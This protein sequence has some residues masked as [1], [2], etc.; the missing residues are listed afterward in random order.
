MIY[1]GP[2]LVVMD[3]GAIVVR[4]VCLEVSRVV[5]VGSKSST[6][7]MV[8]SEEDITLLGHIESW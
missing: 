6:S 2:V 7:S 4:I 1:N 3:R 5:Y 8:D